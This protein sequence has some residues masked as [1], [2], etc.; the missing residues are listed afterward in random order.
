MPRSKKIKKK[1]KSTKKKYTKPLFKFSK[2]VVN[3]TTHS[4]FLDIHFNQ[5]Q[6]NLLSLHLL[7]N[8][9]NMLVKIMLL[10]VKVLINKNILNYYDLSLLQLKKKVILLNILTF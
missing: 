4:Q 3:S 5:Y 2:G 1:R 9:I 8:Y 6:K 7:L 10:L